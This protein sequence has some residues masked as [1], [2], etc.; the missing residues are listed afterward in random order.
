MAAHP[1]YL[2][3]LL[4][5]IRFCKELAQQLAVDDDPPTIPP[6]Y[7]PEGAFALNLGQSN[8]SGTEPGTAT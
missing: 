7:R 3:I 1:C 2:V 5:S 6:D 8:N 4:I